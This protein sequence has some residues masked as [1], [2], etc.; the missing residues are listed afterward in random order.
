MSLEAKQ[1]NQFEDKPSEYS[2]AT[3]RQQVVDLSSK[4][5][6][7]KYRAVDKQEAIRNNF[8]Q[9]KRLLDQPD[10]TLLSESECN[11]AEGLLTNI[12][13]LLDLPVTEEHRNRVNNR[14]IPVVLQAM[15]GTIRESDSA[16]TEIVQE[17][18]ESFS[19]TDELIDLSDS[20]QFEQY[21]QELLEA[22]KKAFSNQQFFKEHRLVQG[23]QALGT[24]RVIF[25]QW[26]RTLQQIKSNQQNNKEVDT[27]L[28]E[29]LNKYYNKILDLIEVVNGEVTTFRANQVAEDEKS[30]DSNPVLSG[31]APA[32][33]ESIIANESIVAS[34]SPAAVPLPT[35]VLTNEERVTEESGAPVT[36]KQPQE[37]TQSPEVSATEQINNSIITIADKYKAERESLGRAA[38][39]LLAK[40]NLPAHV[41]Q[42]LTFAKSEMLVHLEQLSYTDPQY[43]QLRERVK[44][45]INAAQQLTGEDITIAP[46]PK[47]EGANHH[48]APETRKKLS[49]NSKLRAALLVAMVAI[50][51]PNNVS[52]YSDNF[53]VASAD[54]SSP[55]SRM[56]EHAQW[57]GDTA[58][59]ILA[60]AEKDEPKK[61]VVVRPYTGEEEV[62]TVT[63]EAP[64]ET[65]I[66]NMNFASSGETPPSVVAEAGS[67][68]AVDLSEDNLPKVSEI[69][70]NRFGYEPTALEVDTRESMV[71]A[72]DTSVSEPTITKIAEPDPKS[73]AYQESIAPTESVAS[74][75]TVVEVLQGNEATYPDRAIDPLLAAVDAT[76]I[77]LVLANKLR[78]EEK[79]AFLSDANRLRAAG[80]GSGQKNVTFP[81][82]KINYSDPVARLDQRFNEYR[83]YLSVPHTEVAVEGDNLTKLVEKSYARDLAVLS[84][85]DRLPVVEEAL[86]AYLAT[87]GALENLKLKDKDTVPIA[88]VVPLQVLARYLAD[89]VAKKVLTANESGSASEVL[90]DDSST[91]ETIAVDVDATFN[92]SEES[93]SASKVIEDRGEPGEVTS[94]EEYPGGV[95]AFSQA[96]NQLLESFGIAIKAPA[97]FDSWFTVNRAEYNNRELLGMTVGEITTIM[98]Q[99]PVE[100]MRELN[101]RKI[102]PEA[103]NA[104]YQLV[105]EAR[106]NGLAP[107]ATDSTI[108]LEEVIKRKVLADASTNK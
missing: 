72:A 11:L 94:P 56:G 62:S 85:A 55:L 15:P 83:Q 42:S 45:V 17:V 78:A 105:I 30:S 90:V 52:D 4:F 96:Y 54:M 63:A 88:A 64:T 39:E 47:I 82:E 84:P 35:L 43:M 38:D 14:P 106:K 44:E 68:P 77:P 80:V 8:D 70:V 66:T 19:D 10:E 51:S 59:G 87:P 100:V 26:D 18:K 21:D 40:P 2:V 93:G 24:M 7:I 104:V 16:A 86:A 20:A 41:L 71:T 28:Y 50:V 67:L 103:A 57:I 79:E 9:L 98:M 31:D 53:V 29:K 81:G 91:A 65:R 89:A 3:L 73:P 46:A 27:G 23:L 95:I 1:K 69:V 58:S 32:E 107:Y 22:T 48:L 74:G 37:S 12:K 13:T 25:A 5:P 97:M 76:G 102:S 6:N 99:D 75:N 101:A 33:E 34:V 92:A 49:E 61:L 36:L 60:A 108:T